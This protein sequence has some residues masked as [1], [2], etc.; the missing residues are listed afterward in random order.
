VLSDNDELLAEI[1]SLNQGVVRALVGL[2]SL[3]AQDGLR[4]QYVAALLESGL[5]DLGATRFVG[6]DPA[7]LD[8]IIEKSRA[9]Y[10]ELVM[11]L[12]TQ[13]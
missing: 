1:V 8:R 12:N 4:D 11:S 10:T 6:M 3:A 13:Q 7:R 5:R 2:A 9:R